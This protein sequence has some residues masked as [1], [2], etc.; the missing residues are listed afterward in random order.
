MKRTRL[1]IA[2]LALALCVAGRLD[3]RTLR[4]LAIGNSFSVDAAEQ[5]LHEMAKLDGDTLII[6]NLYIG[7]CSLAR[8]VENARGDL[9]AYSYRK[10]GADGIKVKTKDVALSTA[11]A[12]EAWDCVTMQET[13][14]MS[15]VYSSWE[16][17][18]P[19]LQAYVQ[20]RV[21]PDAR[22]MIH[23]TWAYAKD[24]N[25]VGFVNYGHDQA[26]MYRAIVSAVSRIAKAQGINEVIPSGTAIQ[27]GRTSMLGDTFNRD[28]YHLDKGYGRFTAACTWY[29]YLTGRDATLNAFIPEGVTPDQAAVAKRAATEAVKHPWEVTDLSAL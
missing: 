3:A 19:E 13:S 15:G 4:V 27:N 11:L 22:L 18:L 12:D 23:M 26:T 29:A 2:L 9:K 24:S 7:G 25:H 21:K 10:I 20:S 8:H 6:G 28:G 5:Y 16:A 17:W 1:A 14:G